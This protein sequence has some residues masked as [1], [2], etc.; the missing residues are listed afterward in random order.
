M[1]ISTRVTSHGPIFDGRAQRAVR[2]YIDD[3]EEEGAEWALD[4]VRATFH[5]QFKSPTGYY[6]SHVR[7]RQEA[8]GP[9]VTDGGRIE[10][11]PWLE[12]V[13]SRNGT[14]RFKGYRA[15]RR[16]AAALER[17]IEGMGYRLLE[18]RWIRR[19]N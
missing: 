7:V 9:V 16:A 11:G 10:Y 3:L 18:S 15:F 13:G 2:G 19:M 6:E 1:R 4:H 17:R 8:G 14:T 12:G 5:A